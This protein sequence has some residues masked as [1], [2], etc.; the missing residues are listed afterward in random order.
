MEPSSTPTDAELLRR[1][2][3]DPQAFDSVYVRHGRDI[4]RWLAQRVDDTTSWELTAEVFAQAWLARKRFRP[5][6]DGS[7]GPWLQGIA[8]NLWRQW[9]RRQRLDAT[10]TRKLGIQLDLTAGAEEDDTL[11]RLLVEQLG[12]DVRASLHRL[13]DDQ[14]TA[15]ELRIVDELPYDEIARRLDVTPD[16]VRMRVMRGLRALNADLEGRFA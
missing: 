10:A 8:Q 15:I 6:P 16:V 12:G 14:R 7:A 13:P 5:A 11:D 9:S 2:R 1:A 3:R 4:Q